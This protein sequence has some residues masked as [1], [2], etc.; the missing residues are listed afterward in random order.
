M[1]RSSPTITPGEPDIEG[2]KALRARFDVSNVTAN[3]VQPNKAD[4]VDALMLLQRAA[5]GGAYDKVRDSK[6]ILKLADPYRIG[7][8][9]RSFRRFLRPPR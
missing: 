1:R 6:A 9:S 5:K 2:I 8:N 7:Q 4:N 3:A